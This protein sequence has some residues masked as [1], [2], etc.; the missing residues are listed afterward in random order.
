MTDGVVGPMAQLRVSSGP[1]GTCDYGLLRIPREKD[2]LQLCLETI[3]RVSRPR[4]LWVYGANDE[5]IKSV[6]K[7]LAPW[8]DEPFTVGSKFLSGLDCAAHRRRGTER[9]DAWLGVHAMRSRA[10]R[11]WHH[12]PG[13]FA[14]GSLD[15]ATA[16]LLKSLP[17]DLAPR[18]ALDF[19]CGGG[20]IGAE[21]R[22]RWPETA[23]TGIDADALAVEVA[24]R[25]EGHHTVAVSDAWYHVHA[26]GM[27]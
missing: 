27:I 21:L 12:L 17:P 18:T 22:A 7:H 6:Q 10:S 20:V 23:I 3:A 9:L 24:R 13:V 5:G 2:A 16:L 25:N 11:T 1:P 19:A 8:F 4:A 26:L 14:K 15:P